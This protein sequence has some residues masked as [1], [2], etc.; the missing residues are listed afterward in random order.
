LQAQSTFKAGWNTYPVGTVIHEYSYAVNVVADSIRLGLSDSSYTY[1]SPDSLV[2]MTVSHPLR[3]KSVY[4]TIHYFNSKKQII[5]TEEYKDDNQ[6]SLSEWKYDDKNRKLCH[7]Q[8]NKVTGNSYRKTYDYAAEKKSGDFI[9]TE[10]SYY[11][12]RVEFFTKSYYNK[13][14]VKYKEV[15][16]NDNNKDV[17]HIETFSYGDNGKVKERSVYFPEWKVTKKFPENEGMMPEKCYRSLPPGIADR[18]TLSSQLAYIKKV[19]AKNK[20]VLQDA[21]CSSFEY[22]FNYPPTCEVI[23]SPTRVNKN[24]KVV[25]R[26][27]EKPGR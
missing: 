4:K 25:F 26:Y 13:S 15:R 18:P 11:N 17:I 23:V 21:Q 9:V 5:K 1:T 2:T 22:T 3:D 19:V 20:A 8:E 14:L 10:N 6:Q 7:V 27:K 24:M 12:G 16:L